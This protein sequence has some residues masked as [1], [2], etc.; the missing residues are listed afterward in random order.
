MFDRYFITPIIALGL[1]FL[2][3]VY[4]RSR[5]QEVQSYP[6]PIEI[7]LDPQ[8]LDRYSF[9][10][11][12]ENQTVRVKFYGLP[13]RLRE[14]KDQ[15]ES[16]SIVLRHMVKVPVVV[17]QRQDNDYQEVI[18]FDGSSMTLP[19]GV[20]ADINPVEGRLQVKLR[21]MM[22]RT[23][24]L[25]HNVSTGSP[26]YLVDNVRLE[27]STVKI[28]GPKSV[29]EQMNLLVLDSW[30]PRLPNGLTMTE[31]DVRGFVNLPTK[32]KQESIKTVPERVEISARLK[33]AL[34]EYELSDVPI[35]F[36]CPPNFPYRP[37]FTSDR[38]GYI[39]KLK[40]RGPM[41]RTPEVKAY[42]DLTTKQ[43]QNLKTGLYADEAIMLDLPEGFYLAQPQP[44]LSTYRLELIEIR[45]N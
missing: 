23:V 9:D 32:I 44:K 25:Q 21:R 29:L 27:P 3:W 8:Q 24:D 38:L 22:E 34:K 12:P 43:S 13:S 2:V 40:V 18:Q 35:S 11:K 20:H 16:R 1:A 42:V 19:L 17:D 31:E 14:L 33:P 45:G 39:A 36:L 26:Q 6:I 5:D 15:V 10:G 28:I 7:S 41:N 4:L 37:V 30:Q